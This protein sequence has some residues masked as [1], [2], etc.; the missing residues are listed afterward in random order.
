MAV[1]FLI[2]VL[3]PAILLQSLKETL[4]LFPLKFIAFNGRNDIYDVNDTGLFANLGNNKGLWTYLWI[5]EFSLGVA[6]MWEDVREGGGRKGEV[7]ADG[8]QGCRVR[9]WTKLRSRQAG[10]GS[11]AGCW[12]GGRDLFFCS[13]FSICLAM[14][15]C[16]SLTAPAWE[17]WVRG[18]HWLFGTKIGSLPLVVFRAGGIGSSS[19]MWPRDCESVRKILKSW[20]LRAITVLFGPY[21]WDC[22]LCNGACNQVSDSSLPSFSHQ[23]KMM[24]FPRQACDC[25]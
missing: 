25:L 11:L 22:R 15:P 19:P 13:Y 2:S 5:S 4:K 10:L 3:Y 6:R 20:I 8:G 17:S 12:A 24:Y 14:F 9:N 23:R 1:S 18:W 21:S 7:E 16:H